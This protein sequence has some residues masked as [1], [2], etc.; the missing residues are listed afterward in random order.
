MSKSECSSSETTIRSLFFFYFHVAF[1]FFLKTK[2]LCRSLKWH[3]RMFSKHLHTCKHR[4]RTL[5][6]VTNM[7]PGCHWLPRGLGFLNKSPAS[8]VVIRAQ[9]LN[10]GFTW[11]YV[12][13]LRT[14][15]RCPIDNNNNASFNQLLDQRLSSR[16]CL[17]LIRWIKQLD[18]VFLT[19][20]PYTC[21]TQ[22][23]IRLGARWCFPMLKPWR[24][25]R[26]PSFFGHKFCEFDAA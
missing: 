13:M 22:S 3:G 18:K 15:D 8:T 6:Q 1:F 16:G 26:K 11:V 21:N 4:F 17:W 7:E 20:C 23:S 24:S 12:V 25:Q 14:L 2:H 5:E 10:T 9:E 19:L